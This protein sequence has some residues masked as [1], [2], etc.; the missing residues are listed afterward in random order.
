MCVEITRS[1]L[2]TVYKLD[3]RLGGRES[4]RNWVNRTD[5]IMTAITDTHMYGLKS[6]QGLLLIT[7]NNVHFQLDKHGEYTTLY[8]WGL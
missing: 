7:K 8:H 5:A 2:A 1:S 4:G 3:Y 6:Q